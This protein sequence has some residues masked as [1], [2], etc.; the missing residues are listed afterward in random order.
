[1]INLIVEELQTIMARRIAALPPTLRPFTQEATSLP[2]A[3]LLTGARG[4]G[5]STFL[6]HHSKNRKLLYFSADNPLVM[7]LS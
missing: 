4:V 1:M 5:K 3:L 7:T 6:L 2:R